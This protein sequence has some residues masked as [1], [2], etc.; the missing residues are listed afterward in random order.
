MASTLLTSIV[1]AYQL[2]EAS[3]TIVDAVNG[4]N[5]S[6]ENPTYNQPGKIGTAL[7]FLDTDELIT[8][9]DQTAWTITRA[10]NLSISF[11]IYMTDVETTNGRNIFGN[12]YGW[13]IW[14]DE[15]SPPDYLLKWY[16][17]GTSVESNNLT[18][19]INTWYHVVMVKTAEVITFYRNNIAVGG[20]SE[21]AYT[22]VDPANTYIGGDPEGEFTAGRLDMLYFW[23]KALSTDEIAELWNSGSGSAYPFSAG[24]VE[25][26]VQDAFHG[27]TSDVPVL[28]QKHTLVSVDAF[29]ELISDEPVLTQKHILVVAETVHSHSADGNLTLTQ[30]STLVVQ[31]TLHELTSDVPLLTQKHTLS[32]NDSVHGQSAD[33]IVLTEHKTLIVVEAAHALSSDN[34][35]LVQS[36][37]LV[38]SETAHLHTSDNTILTQSHTLAISDTVHA[39][40]VDGDLVIIESG[41][42]ELVV[43][44]AIHSLS[45][46]NI[47]LTQRHVL[48]INDTTHSHL[49]DGLIV[50]ILITESISQA[51]I[52]SAGPVSNP[53]HIWSEIGQRG[54]RRIKTNLSS[55]NT[56]NQRG[57]Q[58]GNRGGGTIR[59]IRGDL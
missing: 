55:I 46:D 40:S 48:D 11:W 23:D 7:A 27:L 42:I 12:Y 54:M 51:R 52:I 28:T 5:S 20:G 15:N 36:N 19:A 22:S 59:R 21:A 47:D 43:Q 10:G 45:S 50:L 49:A 18:W 26:I 6:A 38:V 14:I 8:L 29:H 30:K 17:T 32:V 41:G 2:D 58:G 1:A 44:G 56:G 16:P 34:V 24:S 31:E 13:C 9:T 25:L 39:H 33:N 4:Y 37:I 35:T 53:Q 57:N 3:G